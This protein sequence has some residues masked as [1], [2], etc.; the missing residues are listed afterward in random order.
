MISRPNF[1]PEQNDWLSVGRSCVWCVC[2]ALST[3]VGGGLTIH[4]GNFKPASLLLCEAT[5]FGS[6]I[7]FLCKILRLAWLLL[8]TDG[9]LPTAPGRMA[10]EPGRSPGGALRDLGTWRPHVSSAAPGPWS[11][12]LGL[13][14][15]KPSP[16]LP[17]PAARHQASLPPPSPPP[18]LPQVGRAHSTASHTDRDP[19]LDPALRSQ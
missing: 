17:L 2:S 12:T 6:G 19:A 13:R 16:P 8:Q 7:S 18:P 3:L 9:V 1:P 15:G 5:G 4:T 11:Q 14:R 10:A